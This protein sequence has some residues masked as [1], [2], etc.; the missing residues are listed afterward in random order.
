MVRLGDRV[1]S[2]LMGV[3][4]R[5]ERGHEETEKLCPVCYKKL[6]RVTYRGR[7]GAEPAI[8]ESCYLEKVDSMLMV[9]NEAR[10]AGKRILGVASD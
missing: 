7:G 1:G 8:C 5:V 6:G 3:S 2:V 9:A 10:A 4:G